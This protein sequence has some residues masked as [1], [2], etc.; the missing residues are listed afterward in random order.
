MCHDNEHTNYS[1]QN[2]Y[3]FLLMSTP[4]KLYKRG[5]TFLA[6][7]H[8]HYALCAHNTVQY[9]VKEKI[10]FLPYEHT[11]Y[12]KQKVRYFFLQMST[13]LY[14]KK[15]ELLFLA[16]EHTH[17]IIQKEVGTLSCQ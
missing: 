5:A 13:P 8:T 10:F 1:I 2:I 14:Y 7:E 6:N 15:C 4:I 12:I 11:H 17:Y 16:N 3:Y 9:Y